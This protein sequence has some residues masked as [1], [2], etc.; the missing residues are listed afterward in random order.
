MKNLSF[1]PVVLLGTIALVSCST[2]DSPVATSVLHPVVLTGGNPAAAPEEGNPDAP[3]NVFFGF[4]DGDG[5][6]TT[7]I[8]MPAESSAS[9]LLI[10]RWNITKLGIDENNDGNIVSYNYADYPHKDCGNSFLQ[11]NNDGVVFENSY[12]EV[13]GSCTLFAEIDE[14]EVIGENRFRI[15]NYDNI[16]LVSLTQSELVLK[17]DWNFENSLYGPMQVYYYYTRV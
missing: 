6:S 12:F 10:G 7:Y 14:L 8:D 5:S 2:D 15:Y 16:Y 3:A 9:N 1:F 11:F 13:D 4:L 17:Y